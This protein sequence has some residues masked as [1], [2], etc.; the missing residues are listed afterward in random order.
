MRTTVWRNGAVYTIEIRQFDSDGFYRI[1]TNDKEKRAMKKALK[2]AE[3][4][5]NLRLPEEVVEDVSTRKELASWEDRSPKMYHHRLEDELAELKK[6]LDDYRVQLA[7]LK[8]IHA[9]DKEAQALGI[10]DE[11]GKVFV[12]QDG[13]W[14]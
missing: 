4:H 5:L 8:D 10:D 14:D 7:A 6:V 1:K 13:D 9:P 3:H 12:P 11:S 2:V